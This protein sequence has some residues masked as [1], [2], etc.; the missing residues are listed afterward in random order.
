MLSIP[1]LVLFNG[2]VTLLDPKQHRCDLIITNVYLCRAAGSEPLLDTD[3]IFA[4]S[5]DLP[6]A[7]CF[8]VVEK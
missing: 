4:V 2:K 6:Q 8:S 5:C 1:C 7:S 3:A